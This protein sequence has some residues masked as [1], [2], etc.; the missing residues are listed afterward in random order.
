MIEVYI[1]SDIDKRASAI[2]HRIDEYT[3]A[4]QSEPEIVLISE[5]QILNNKIEEFIE[6]GSLFS[7]HRVVVVDVSSAGFELVVPFFARMKEVA[8]LFILKMN[9]LSVP[10]KKELLKFDVPYF[11]YMQKSSKFKDESSIFGLT[12]L[13]I[14]R[15]KKNLWIELDRTRRKGATADI[16]VATLLWQIK[17]IILARFSG[18][19]SVP[20]KIAKEYPFNK[21]KR[22]TKYSRQ[23]LISL[24]EKLMIAQSKSR[25]SESNLE[26]ELE[27]ILLQSI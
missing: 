14:A 16:V 8:D 18:E 20:E 6:S 26:C 22:A 1:G 9:V 4:T 17:L 11:E 19:Q 12:D 27:R 15:D 7:S 3:R 21:S 5:E 24:Y 10:H 23:E 13:L 2:T 25:R